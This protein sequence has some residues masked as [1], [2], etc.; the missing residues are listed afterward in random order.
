[1]KETTK[2]RKIEKKNDIPLTL[3]GVRMHLRPRSCTVSIAVP[4][5]ILQRAQSR[6]LKTLLAGQIGRAAAIC[7]IDEIV[8]Y[9]EPAIESTRLARILEYLETPQYL[10]K[11]LCPVHTDLGA[12]GILPPLDAPHHVRATEPSR[13]RE[14][15]VTNSSENTFHVDVGIPSGD[16][17]CTSGNKS[18]PKKGTRITIDMQAQKPVAPSKPRTQLG[19]YWGYQTRIA[20]SLNE[21]LHHMPNSI[22]RYD[23]VIA[24][25]EKGQSIQTNSFSLPP[26]HNLIVLFGGVDGLEAN[27]GHDLDKYSLWLNVC[28]NQGSRT[29]R[30]EEAVLLAMAKLQPHIVS[31]S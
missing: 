5:S 18:Q 24:T 4:G 7:E 15:V 20:V 23:L 26:F 28:P 27:P 16:L 3:G 22:P 8:V 17:C 29:I 30:T 9:G 21:V 31:S 14:G 13:Y 6:E 25:S 10:R 11:T 19:L 1:M 12:V 2:R